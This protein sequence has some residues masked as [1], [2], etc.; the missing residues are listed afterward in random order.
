M[1]LYGSIISV[2][3]YF[4]SMLFYLVSLIFLQRPHGL[5]GE[6]NQGQHIEDGHERNADI[7][8]I[9]HKGIGLQPADKEHDQSQNLIER[10]RRPVITK[11]IRDIRPGVKQ[12]ADKGGE[13]EQ[14]QDHGDKDHAKAS[15]VIMHGGL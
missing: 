6:G 14:P 8:Q 1:F 7:A 9:P 10:L 4:K 13:A 12:D 3:V 11:Q 2:E 5:P 15:K